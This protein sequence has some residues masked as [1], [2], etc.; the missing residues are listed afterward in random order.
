MGLAAYA[1]LANVVYLL[2]CGG[3]WIRNR[4]IFATCESYSVLIDAFLIPIKYKT[5]QWGDVLAN[6][7][8]SGLGLFLSYHAERK[9]RTRREIERLYEPLD[10]E[11]FGDHDDD[12]DSNMD[13]ND[14]W[15]TAAV[16]VQD[17]VRSQQ[18][19]VQHNSQ[20]FSIADEED[21]GTDAWKG[22]N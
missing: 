14:A 2:C 12:I 8:G 1:P 15:R 7:V 22:H 19:D 13:T 11:L 9:Y 18:L 10:Q 6:F 5:F 17:E 3:T 16:N 4:A 21:E 20:L